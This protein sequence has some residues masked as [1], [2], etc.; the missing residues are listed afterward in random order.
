MARLLSYKTLLELIRQQW[1]QNGKEPSI[2]I[3]RDRFIEQFGDIGFELINQFLRDLD[4]R[5]RAIRVKEYAYSYKWE[6]EEYMNLSAEEIAQKDGTETSG[7]NIEAINRTVLTTSLVIE[8]GF[9]N[10]LKSFES[11]FQEDAAE[12]PVESRA[13][14]KLILRGKRLVLEFEKNTIQL[15]EFRSKKDKGYRACEALLRARGQ[16]QE[17]NGLIS[18]PLGTNTAQLP[19]LMH[20]PS[21]VADIFYSYDKKQCALRHR[22]E[23][24]SHQATALRKFVNSLK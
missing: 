2:E 11:P 8:P 15:G 7:K 13:T 16:M 23:L 6:Y 1:E 9:F 4:E 17:K 22:V 5:Y 18:D 10:V 12:S 24:S 14:A 20:L 21:I 3:H 19:K